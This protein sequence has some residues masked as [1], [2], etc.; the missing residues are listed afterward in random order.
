MSV[1]SIKLFRRW[2]WIA[3]PKGSSTKSLRDIWCKVFGV[4]L[5]VEDLR[6]GC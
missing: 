5:N 4:V 6:L 2:S 3:S 1:Y